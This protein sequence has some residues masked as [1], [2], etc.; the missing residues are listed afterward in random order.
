MN[1]R[2]ASSADSATVV[3]A[4][5]NEAAHLEAM[6]DRLLAVTR[7]RPDFDSVVVLDDASGDGSADWPSRLACR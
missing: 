2:R 5:Y 4:V 6:M 7:G 1:S 3:V